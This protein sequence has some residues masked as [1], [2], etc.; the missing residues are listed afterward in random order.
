MVIKDK[1]FSKIALILYLLYFMYMLPNYQNCKSEDKMPN[2]FMRNKKFENMGLNIGWKV[3]KT[4]KA[5][6]YAIQKL[7][8]QLSI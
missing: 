6:Y 7:Q 1:T 2:I 8:K 3:N 4:M 5:N